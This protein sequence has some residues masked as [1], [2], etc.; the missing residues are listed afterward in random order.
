MALPVTVF[1]MFGEKDDVSEFVSPL[2][3]VS[4]RD[5]STVTVGVGEL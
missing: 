3:A 2:V 5:S 4:V 1:V